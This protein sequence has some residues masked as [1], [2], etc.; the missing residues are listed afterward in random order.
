MARAGRDGLA[1]IGADGGR[2]LTESLIVGE[3]FAE[4]GHTGRPPR[5]DLQE[6]VVAALA[7]APQRG[8]Q[9]RH[10]VVV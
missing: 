10:A 6:L 2:H 3:P 7:A 8:T 1:V 5:L 9:R 4:V